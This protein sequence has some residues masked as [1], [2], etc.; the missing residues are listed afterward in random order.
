MK[1]SLLIFRLFILIFW[2]LS[3]L[4][5]LLN[6]TVP[7][8]I[9]CSLTFKKSVVKLH[10]IVTLLS[11]F[12][13]PALNN[14][15][16]VKLFLNLYKESASVKSPPFICVALRTLIPVERIYISSRCL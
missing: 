12:A 2:T 8:N 10:P 5:S 14:F 3:K 9:E 6:A 11:I 16:T 15:D 7:S 13:S 1:R 4:T